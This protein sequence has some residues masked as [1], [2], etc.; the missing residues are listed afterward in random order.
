MKRLA[1]LVLML[2]LMA[3]ACGGSV[4]VDSAESATTTQATT[5]TTTVAPTTTTEPP[6]TTTTT[7]EPAT[8]T[9]TVAE[10]GIA[11]GDDPE[12]DAIV[13]AYTIA[14]GYTKLGQSGPALMYWKTYLDMKDANEERRIEA[15]KMAQELAVTSSPKP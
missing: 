3:S 12:V 4:E 2:A 13:L 6:T 10:G 1:M 5:T 15:K 7:T 11:A 9:T 14:L 8:T